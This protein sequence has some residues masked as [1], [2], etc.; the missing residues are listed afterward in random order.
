MIYT[1][2]LNPAVD[3]IFEMDELV[4]GAT[5]TGLPSRIMPAGKGLNAARAAR[6]LGAPT[7][8]VAVLPEQSRNMFAEAASA[9]D[10][11]THVIEVPGRAR[12]NVTV[13][14]S[15]GRVSHLNALSAP[16]PEDTEFE[17]LSLISSLAFFGDV[18][19]LVG[20][21]PPGISPS[22]YRQI[23]TVLKHAGCAVILDTSGEAL[24]QGFSAAP[25][26]LMPNRAELGSLFGLS[27]AD[28]ASVIHAADEVLDQGLSSVLITLGRDGAYAA[29]ASER[30][31]VRIPKI[32]AVDTVGCG[33]AAAAG[34]AVGLHRNLDFKDRCRLATAA[35]MSAALHKGPGI[36]AQ[37][38]VIAFI[39]R[40]V[41]ED[42]RQR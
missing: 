17:V 38:D 41:F 14:E 31:F 18:W 1:L 12:T 29:R 37:D 2:L 42:V 26:M 15:T 9:F 5:V 8:M 10:I 36:L 22:I 13:L 21:V 40:I 30:F 34:M 27:C 24:H 28:E 19:I 25:T 32:D 35:A 23:I 4:A 3:V 33:D 11:L 39:E 20:S 6:F 16:V 7:T